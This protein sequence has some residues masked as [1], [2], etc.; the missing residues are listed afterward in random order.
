MLLYTILGG[1]WAV[2]V[3]DFVQLVLALFGD[4]GGGDDEPTG[5]PTVVGHGQ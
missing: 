2:V 5:P 4:G 3:N 1:L